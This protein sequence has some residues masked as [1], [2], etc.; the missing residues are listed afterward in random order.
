MKS[1]L[2]LFLSVLLIFAINS[3]AQN[4]SKMNEM[5]RTKIKRAYETFNSY[6]YSNL[7]DFIDVNFIE[8]SP[9]PGQ[10]QGLD[11]LKDAMMNLHKAYPDYKF[12]IDDIIVNGDKASVLFTFE[13]TNSGDM[14]GMKAT[15]K[16]VNIQGIDYLYFK[17]GKCI[18][19][20]GYLDFPKM[21]Q[22]LGMSK[23]Q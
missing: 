16:Q 23:D 9:D 8:H 7:G 21:M 17:D 22:Q 14:M 6:D 1:K 19:H 10:K 18:E 15:N 2:I 3:F 12:T 13:G 20:W 11:G 4:T 5:L